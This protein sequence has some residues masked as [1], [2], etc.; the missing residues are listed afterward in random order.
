[1]SNDRHVIETKLKQALQTK[2]NIRIKRSDL[3]SDEARIDVVIQTLRSLLSDLGREELDLN[4]EGTTTPKNI[5]KK[6]HGKSCKMLILETL[7]SSSVPLSTKEIMDSIMAKGWT[8]S[9]PKPLNVTVG[10]AMKM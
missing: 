3:D 6:S 10:M 9:S 1:M 7:K 2:E 5:R 4:T 8:T